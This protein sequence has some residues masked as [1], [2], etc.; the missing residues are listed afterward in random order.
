MRASHGEMMHYVHSRVSRE[1]DRW[2]G[3]KEPMMRPMNG[4]S[5]CCNEEPMTMAM[6][7]P[8]REGGNDDAN[9]GTGQ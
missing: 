9:E 8:E 5:E 4:G 7:R 2:E 6:M 3:E 1:Q